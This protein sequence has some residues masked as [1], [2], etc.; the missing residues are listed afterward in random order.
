MESQ[1]RR[2]NF[3]DRNADVHVIRVVMDDAYPLM[4]SVPQLLAKT[5]FDHPQ[6]LSIGIFSPALSEMSRMIGPI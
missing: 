3:V 5:L 2:V 4:F 6:R 1:S